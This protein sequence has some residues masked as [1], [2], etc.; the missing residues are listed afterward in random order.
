MDMRFGTWNVR[1]LYRAG[2][3]MTVGKEIPKYCI[4]EIYWEYR[5]DG[6]AG[7][8]ENF[9]LMLLSPHL[10]AVQYHDI[11]RVTDTLKMWHNKTSGNDSN[12]SKFDSGGN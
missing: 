5:S 8:A 2:S 11:K 3:L 1:C 6:I 4:S 7:V 10:N 12:K 9:F